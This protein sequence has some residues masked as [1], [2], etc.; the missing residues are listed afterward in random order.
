[1]D[2]ELSSLIE[3]VVAIARHAGDEIMKIYESDFDVETKEDHSPLTDADRAAHQLICRELSQLTPDIPVWSEESATIP[4][5]KRAGWPEFWLV[6]PLD[7]T[8][9]FIKHNGEFTVNIALIQQHEPVLGVVHVPAMQRD[10]FGYR[11]GGAFMRSADGKQQSIHVTEECRS[12]V[13]VVGS[14]SHRGASLEAFLQK[15]GDHEMVPMG[16]SLKICLVAAGDADIYPRLGPT[17]E[18]DTAAA[19]AVVDCAGGSLVDLEGR[20]LRYNT[21]AEVLNP[22]FLVFGDKNKDWPTWFD[23]RKAPA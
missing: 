16:S 1:M 9:E 7:G 19:H 17:S 3:P 12:A 8:K 5:E 10:Y 6:D 13:R 18:W 20:A 2:I 14:R 21:K 22:Y 23:S 11:H 15:I 4:F